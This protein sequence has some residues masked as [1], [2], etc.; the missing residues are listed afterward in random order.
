MIEA[1]FVGER[2][3]SRGKSLPNMRQEANLLPTYFVVLITWFIIFW[4]GGDLP[5]SMVRG[6]GKFT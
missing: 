1:T 4:K 6:K 5:C 3:L 2:M